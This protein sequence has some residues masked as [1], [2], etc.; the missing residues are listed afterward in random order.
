MRLRRPRPKADLYECYGPCRQWKPGSAFGNK[1]NKSGIVH[2]AMCRVCRRQALNKW[3]GD[4]YQSLRD[5]PVKMIEAINKFDLLKPV[6]SKSDP[7]W[8]SKFYK[9]VMAKNSLMARLGLIDKKPKFDIVTYVMRKVAYGRISQEEAEDRI[10][11]WYERHP[12]VKRNN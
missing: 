8:I 10:E 4:Y 7:L 2:A 3:L 9:W 6:Y 12:E 5:D 11:N 1:T